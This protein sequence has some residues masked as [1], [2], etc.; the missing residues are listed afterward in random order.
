MHHQHIQRIR[1]LRDRQQI[2]HRI[3]RQLFVETDI[4]GN[5]A[6]DA[7]QQRVAV[8]WRFGGNVDA[9]VAARSAAVIDEYLLV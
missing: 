4:D 2:L 9:D 1:R 3:K 5:G 6:D 8:R 7:E